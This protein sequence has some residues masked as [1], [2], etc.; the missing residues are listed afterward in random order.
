MAAFK[1]NKLV[2]LAIFSITSVILLIFSELLAMA[3]TMLTMAAILST[4]AW[5]REEIGA[6]VK[7]SAAKHSLKMPQLMMPLRAIIV[8]TG[9]TPSLDAVIALSPRERVLGRLEHYLG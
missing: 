9:Q 3:V 2:L 5:T 8:G 4:L 1:D 6:L 7:R